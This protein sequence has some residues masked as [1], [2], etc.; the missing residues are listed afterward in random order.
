[1]KHEYTSETANAARLKGLE[2]R[3]ANAA[4]RKDVLSL[5]KQHT[6]DDVLKK[7]DLDLNLTP[8]AKQEL[9]QE[10]FKQ[11]VTIEFSE[12]LKHRNKLE[13]MVLKQEL[14]EMTKC[15]GERTE[16]SIATDEKMS[17]EELL[18]HDKLDLSRLSE[19]DLNLL[20]SFV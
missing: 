8:Q 2:T 20:R 9:A 4:R 19:Q 11:L 7:H 1:M 6:L 12:N 18:E 17:I 16:L 5:L 3:R 14:D 15:L 10:V 13:Q